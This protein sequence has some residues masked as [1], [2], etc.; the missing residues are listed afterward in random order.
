MKRTTRTTVVLLLAALA[1][2]E[3]GLAQVHVFRDI[4]L[5][6]SRD[7]SRDTLV[8]RHAGVINAIRVAIDSGEM[9]RIGEAMSTLGRRLKAEHAFAQLEM[10]PIRYTR[11]DTID[12]YLTVDVVDSIDIHRLAFDPPPEDDV[13]G[14]DD[15]IQAWFDF[16]AAG[17][18]S[19]AFWSPGQPCPALHCLFT[20]DRPELAPYRTTFGRE[21]VE[22]A[23][24]LARVAGHDRTPAKRAAAVYLLAHLNDPSRVADIL[25]SRA[26]DP[27][28]HVRNNALRVLAFMVDHRGHTELPLDPILPLLDGPST[29]DRNKAV[30]IVAGLARA[31]DR[32]DEIKRRAGPT[33]LGLLALEQPN[34]H[35]IAYRALR[36][37]SER[38]FSP[39]DYD[40]WGRWLMT[41]IRIPRSR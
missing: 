22:K 32:R 29:T 19:S 3:S 34:N 6:R 41:T 7:L 13:G 10:S 18:Q 14:A 15:L 39:R 11:G 17:A 25:L 1:G 30:A 23:D 8:S 5:Y 21:V 36:T 2:Q 31:A 9:E 24:V 40:A 33:L 16:E 26:R 28:S 35:E 12:W 20:F 37:L 27:S 38:D 4:D